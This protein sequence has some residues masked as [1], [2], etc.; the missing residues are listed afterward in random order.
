MG[1]NCNFGAPFG[2]MVANLQFDALRAPVFDDHHVI[3]KAR[4]GRLRAR[5]ALGCEA[6]LAVNIETSNSNSGGSLCGGC[7]REY[8]RECNQAGEAWPKVSPCRNRKLLRN[9]APILSS[10]FRHVQGL[11]QDTQYLH[12][13]KISPAIMLL[14]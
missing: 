12:M 7:V 11:P 8:G 1:W 6:S 4:I 14:T 5:N 9:Q 13:S 10:I 3:E 2:F